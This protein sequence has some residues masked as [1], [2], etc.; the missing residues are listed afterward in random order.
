ME[1]KAVKAGREKSLPAK[2]FTRRKLKEINYYSKSLM[3]QNLCGSIN[4]MN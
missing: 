2:L 1:N 3:N 4:R